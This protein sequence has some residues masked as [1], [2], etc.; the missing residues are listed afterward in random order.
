MTQTH[1]KN[2]QAEWRAEME[3]KHFKG[4]QGISV[5]QG[6]KYHENCNNSKYHYSVTSGSFPT[7]DQ[8]RSALRLQ[9]PVNY[10]LPLSL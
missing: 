6:L 10:R 4:F 3:I 2:L 8:P 1:V 5:E 9:T 7:R